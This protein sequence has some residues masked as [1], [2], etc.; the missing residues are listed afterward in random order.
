MNKFIG[1]EIC[2][3][4][5][6]IEWRMTLQSVKQRTH[7][8]SRFWACC[9][10]YYINDIA[11]DS[12]MKYIRESSNCFGGSLKLPYLYDS[13]CLYFF[14][15]WH[16]VVVADEIEFWV[17]NRQDVYMLWYVSHHNTRVVLWYLC[18]FPV[19]FF[20]N[21]QPAEVPID[22]FVCTVSVMIW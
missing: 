5:Q 10:I 1:A 20:N 16:G 22:F 19:R 12:C 21:S 4:W 11:I 18:Q 8:S 13:S 7:R 3:P 15:I 2:W 9:C 17:R 6:C 14:Q